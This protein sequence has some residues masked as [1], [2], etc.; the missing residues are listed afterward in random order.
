MLISALISAAKQNRYGTAD[1][2][3]KEISTIQIPVM[4]TRSV[5]GRTGSQRS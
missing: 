4:T 2:Q 5:A 1:S 3:Q